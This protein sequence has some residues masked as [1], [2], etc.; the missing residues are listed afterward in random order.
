M[1]YGSELARIELIK[2]LMCVLFVHVIILASCL[3]RDR[4]CWV[5]NGSRRPIDN[6]PQVNNLPH[7]GD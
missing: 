4:P 2:Q 7:F 6:R 1:G 5:V 3:I